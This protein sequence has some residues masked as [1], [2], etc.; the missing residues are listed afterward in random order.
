[1]CHN[2]KRKEALELF[3]QE[4]F[5]DA[6]R[7]FGEVLG[8]EAPDGGAGWV[9]FYVSVPDLD[10]TLAKAQSLGWLY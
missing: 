9:T 8:E 6:A 10:A 7:L 2:P 3:H 4:Q 1:M 5:E